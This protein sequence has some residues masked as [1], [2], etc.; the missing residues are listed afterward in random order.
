[1]LSGTSRSFKAPV[2]DPLTNGKSAVRSAKAAVRDAFTHCSL[3]PRGREVG[4]D[5]V[6]VK[7]KKDGTVS[8][9]AF[10]RFEDHGPLDE[11]DVT[12]CVKKELKSAHLAAFT[13][14]EERAQ[15]RMYFSR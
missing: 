5:E 15:V 13:S 9:I 10:F 7:F 3:K 1:M 6:L 14:D 2:T 12:R 8:D 4:A 11:S